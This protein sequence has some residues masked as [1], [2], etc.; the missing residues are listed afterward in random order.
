MQ[1]RN[2]NATALAS[3]PFG[4]CTIAQHTLPMSLDSTA[5]V[6]TATGKVFPPALKV[7]TE[8]GLD[9]G[10]WNCFHSPTSL[11]PC[12]FL[13]RPGPTRVRFHGLLKA[14]E[15]AS[16]E[17]SSRE[18]RGLAWSLPDP[19]QCPTPQALVASSAQWCDLAC[20]AWATLRLPY[21]SPLPLQVPRCST[22][23]PC[24]PFLPL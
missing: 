8:T 15:T 13:M 23:L 20:L 17:P 9:G 24:S 22:P 18:A 16:D 10:S 7:R 2:G 5:T 6:G 11:S 4:F 1:I 21:S 3:R 14:P 12:Y 19:C